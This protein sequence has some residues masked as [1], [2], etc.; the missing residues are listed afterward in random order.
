MKKWIPAGIG[1]VFLLVSITILAVQN[2]VYAQNE[3]NAEDKVITLQNQLDVK[4]VEAS[5]AQ[6]E[7]KKETTG[8]DTQRV[9]SDDAKFKEFIEPVFTWK[10]GEEYDAARN[11][12]LTQLDEKSEFMTT[13][14]PKQKKSRDGQYNYVDSYELNCQFEGMSSYV[15][16]VDGTQY[17]YLTFV[18]YSVNDST[19]NDAKNQ[20]VLTY[21]ILPDG[22]VTNL[23][24]YTL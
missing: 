12:M 8:L 16:K 3:K 24:G 14:M 17:S 1:L 4:Q 2:N 19:G 22:T 21:T 15:T 13:V 18:V 10:T 7:L 11:K 9:K 5:R 20:C 6:V 23:R